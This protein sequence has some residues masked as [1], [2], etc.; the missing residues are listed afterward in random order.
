MDNQLPR[1]PSSA[2]DVFL[3]LGIFVTLYTGV[4]SLGGVVFQLINKLVPDPLAS[5]YPYYADGINQALR[6]SVA[7][8]VVAVP[9]CLWLSAIAARQLR[10]DPAKL[11]TA[12]RRGLTFFTLFVAGA[13]MMGTLISIINSLLGGDLET[14]FILK[15]LSVLVLGGATFG[16]HLWEVRQHP[17]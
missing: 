9:L 10:Q 16:Y 13:V 14:R 15:A 12:I 1:T 2:Q 11:R 7:S 4:I 3:N 17:V 5:R 6:F 8:L